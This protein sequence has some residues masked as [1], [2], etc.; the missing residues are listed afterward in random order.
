MTK[1]TKEEKKKEKKKEK[2][3][4]LLLLDPLPL[5][6][7]HSDPLEEGIFPIFPC[8]L[9]FIIFFF[10]QPL[11]MLKRTSTLSRRTTTKEEWEACLLSPCRAI[12]NS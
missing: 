7:F 1:K 3:L 11:T 6:G 4:T 12:L 8:W 2:K 10:P 5:L 9:L